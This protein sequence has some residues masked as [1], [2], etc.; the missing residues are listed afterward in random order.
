MEPEIRI[1][2]DWTPN[3]DKIHL[4]TPCCCSF[5][6]HGIF[7]HHTTHTK[8]CERCG[9]SIVFQTSPDTRP[10]KKRSPFTQERNQFRKDIARGRDAL[11]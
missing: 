11:V 3:T 9:A 2:R 5:Q 8:I 7:K 6:Q 4:K 10:L 1:V